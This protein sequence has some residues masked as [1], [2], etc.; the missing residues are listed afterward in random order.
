MKAK[1]LD[2][3]GDKKDKVLKR[4]WNFI[5]T[6]SLT[7]PEWKEHWKGWPLFRHLHGI[8]L[9]KSLDLMLLLD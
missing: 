2:L 3:D 9:R 8:P 1:R 4:D 6:F 7:K 5:E